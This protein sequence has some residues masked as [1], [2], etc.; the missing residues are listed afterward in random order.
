MDKT[1]KIVSGG[2]IEHTSSHSFYLVIIKDGVIRI[3][4]RSYVTLGDALNSSEDQPLY[5]ATYEEVNFVGEHK[6]PWVK[7]YYGPETYPG[8]EHVPKP[9]FKKDES[10]YIPPMQLISWDEMDEYYGGGH[11]IQKLTL[12]ERLNTIRERYDD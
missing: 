9:D 2:V 1:A 10:V 3:S 11:K 6:Y 5:H 12:S 4:N 7:N 8:A